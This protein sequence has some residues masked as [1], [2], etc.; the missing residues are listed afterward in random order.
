MGRTEAD[1]EIAKR[2]LVVEAEFK[3]TNKTTLRSEGSSVFEKE[4]EEQKIHQK[5]I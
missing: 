2:A 4:E 3:R 1:R 5:S